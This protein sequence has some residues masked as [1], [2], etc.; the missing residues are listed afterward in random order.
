MKSLLAG[1]LS[2]DYCER[3]TNWLKYPLKSQWVPIG[4][5]AER[6]EVISG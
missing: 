5:L 6:K 4:Q 2:P 3:K 1:A